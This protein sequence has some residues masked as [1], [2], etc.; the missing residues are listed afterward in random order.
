MLLQRK[1]FC[2]QSNQNLWRY[3]YE[4]TREGEPSGRAEVSKMQSARGVTNEERG[5]EGQLQKLRLGH[6]VGSRHWRVL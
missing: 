6:L 3:V 1:K 4:W 5:G 2:C